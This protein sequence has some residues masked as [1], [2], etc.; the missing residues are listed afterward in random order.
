MGNKYVVYTGN[1]PLSYLST[2]KLAASE[3]RW[4]AQLAS[5]DFEV[6]YRSGQC[7]TNADAL[8]R[9]HAPDPPDVEAMLP[10]TAMPKDLQKVLE[11][12]K[13]KASQAAVVVL[14]QRTTAEIC[15][16]QEPDP[17]LQELLVF[18]RRGQHPS[19]EEQAKMS[20]LMLVLFQQ[21]DRFVMRDGVTPLYRKVHYIGLM[22]LTLCS[23][24]CYPVH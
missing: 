14:P 10:G 12:R 18:W 21:W 24:Y 19:R 20:Q 9:Q 11:S 13:V 15:A 17:V 5:F 16:L 1:N 7:N 8:S 2:T 6:K 22:V 23:S 4:A 3:Q